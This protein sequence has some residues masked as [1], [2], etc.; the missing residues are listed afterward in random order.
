MKCSLTRILRIS[1][2][3]MLFCNSQH[4][5]YSPLSSY[6]P[7]PAFTHL[8]PMHPLGPSEKGWLASRSS[9]ALNSGSSQR[10]GLNDHGSWKFLGSM[11]DAKGAAETVIYSFEYRVSYSS[12]TAFSLRA[13]NVLQAATNAH[14]PCLRRPAPPLAV[15]KATEGTSAFLP[16]KWRSG[17]SDPR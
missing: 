3:P 6:R 13:V 8:L 12:L 11:L 10:S 5:T 15:Q 17:T 2:H 16:G 7:R 14:P 9:S 1:I 4:K